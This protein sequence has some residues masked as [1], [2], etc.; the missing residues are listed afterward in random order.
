MSH[1]IEKALLCAVKMG[2][3]LKPM[4]EQNQTSVFSAVLHR[5]NLPAVF[6][7]LLYPSFQHF[8]VSTFSIYE[9]RSTCRKLPAFGNLSKL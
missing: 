7:K 2:R 5:P 1:Q 6:S 4:F 3:V 9:H 8:R